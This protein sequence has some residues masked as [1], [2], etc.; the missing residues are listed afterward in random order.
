VRTSNKLFK[1]YLAD[2]LALLVVNKRVAARCLASNRKG[3]LGAFLDELKLALDD[4]RAVL[5]VI[6][7][8][9]GVRMNP[10]KN[11]LGWGATIAGQ[12]KLNGSLIAYSDL[13][14]LYELESLC[15]LT[16]L[17]IWLWRMLQSRQTQDVQRLI[18]RAERHRSG[19]DRFRVEAGNR[20]FA[21]SGRET[22]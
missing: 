11:A 18:E 19:L 12:L 17:R 13:S 14:R 9:M 10:V 15:V 6:M 8:D 4:D 20:A 5:Q 21:P 16:D 2:S 7:A 22:S 3:P 1:I